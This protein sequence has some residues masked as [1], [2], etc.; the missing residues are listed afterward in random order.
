[1]TFRND[2]EDDFDRVPF[3]DAFGSYI[4]NFVLGVDEASDL[5]VIMSI[6]FI[7]KLNDPGIY[8]LVFGIEE[9]DMTK[10]D[11]WQYGRDYSIETSK[12]YVP[13]EHREHVLS[14]VLEAIECIVKQLP[15]FD[16]PVK[17]SMKSFYRQSLTA[18][19]REEW[20]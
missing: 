5:L 17:I 1:M 3:C 13:N 14:L 4:I 11:D 16:K 8:E 6:A 10:T 18:R 15:A 7:A 12:R 19:V 2:I 9:R 20:L